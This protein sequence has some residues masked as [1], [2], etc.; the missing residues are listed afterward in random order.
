MQADE[1][2]GAT[3]EN[4]F[5]PISLELFVVLLCSTLP[6][7]KIVCH[8]AFPFASS[9]FILCMHF[10]AIEIFLLSCTEYLRFAPVSRLLMCCYEN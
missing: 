9:S 2:E 3:N 7:F 5:V 6:L 1:P 8:Y 10:L 4:E